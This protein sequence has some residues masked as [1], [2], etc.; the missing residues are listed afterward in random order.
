MPDMRRVLLLAVL[1]LTLGLALAPAHALQWEPTG[2][3][4]LCG[5]ARAAG[6]TEAEAIQ[7]AVDI[8]KKS[9][10]FSSYT[11]LDSRCNTTTT[12]TGTLVFCSAEVRACG[13]PKPRFP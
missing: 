10:W 11:V 9:W 1:A 5:T 6:D 8:L 13:I 3:I 12:P 7:N 2:P 4:V